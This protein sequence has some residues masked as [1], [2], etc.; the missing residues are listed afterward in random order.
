VG[1]DQIGQLEKLHGALGGRRPWPRS[2]VKSDT[3]RADG[4]FDITGI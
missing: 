4:V 3:G 1:L 2:T